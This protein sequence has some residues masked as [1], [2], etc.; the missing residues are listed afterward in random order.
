M[1]RA[2][3]MSDDVN[4]LAS[5]TDLLATVLETRMKGDYIA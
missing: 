5:D 3:E 2:L 4:M 1:I